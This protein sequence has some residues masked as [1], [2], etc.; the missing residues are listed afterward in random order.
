MADV[1]ISPRLHEFVANIFDSNHKGRLFTMLRHPVERALSLYYYLGFASW[2]PMFNPDIAN[3]TL[4][5]YA[6]SGYLEHNWVTRFLV[7]KPGG[8]LERTDM[9]LAKEILRSK[10]LVGI[11]DEMESSLAHFAAYFDWTSK[12]TSPAAAADCQKAVAQAG[13]K[14]HN[15]PPVLGNSPEWEAIAHA[16]K[17]DLELYEYAKRLY[18]HQAEQIFHEVANKKVA[19]ES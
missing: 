6:K 3:M 10:C 7:N 4:M 9:V 12:G 17:F 19:T 15:H 8:A 11:F 5:E 18:R 13:D 14:R 1:M 2:D 16:N